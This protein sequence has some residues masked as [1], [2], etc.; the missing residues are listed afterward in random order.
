MFTKNYAI[1][2]DDYKLTKYKL[3]QLIDK[4]EWYSGMDYEKRLKNWHYKSIV[5]SADKLAGE[6]LFL[7]DKMNKVYIE[8]NS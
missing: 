1:I 8:F 5:N 7:E 3:Q 6:I 2:A 4:I